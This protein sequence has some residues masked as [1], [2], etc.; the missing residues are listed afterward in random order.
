MPSPASEA[1]WST[2]LDAEGRDSEEEA[3]F[4]GFLVGQGVPGDAS[5]D[6]LQT[7]YTAF[8][9]FMEESEQRESADPGPTAVE[10][11]AQQA[12]VA[13]Q[14]YTVPKSRVAAPGVEKSPIATTRP[15]ATR[16]APAA[17]DAPPSPDAPR[18]AAAE[19]DRPAPP[20]APSEPD[21]HR[22]RQRGGSGDN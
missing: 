8:R 9:S 7:A 19:P 1:W 10:L 16:Q 13:A 6:A 2:F 22:G 3:A 5:P 15:G 21:T 14:Q 4:L 17:A 20:E 18:A 11:A 12:Q